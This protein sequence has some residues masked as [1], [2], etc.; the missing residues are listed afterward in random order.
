MPR[1]NT[2]DSTLDMK[3]QCTEADGCWLWPRRFQTGYGRVSLHGKPR[4]AH[5]LAW[6]LT[7]GP[8]PE[9]MHICHR[10]D[11]RACC[12]PDHLFLGTHREN[13]ADMVAKGRSASADRHPHAVLSPEQVAEIRR[14][15][16]DGERGASLAKEFGVGQAAASRLIRGR[17]WTGA[18][19]PILGDLRSGSAHHSA[20]LTEADVRAIRLDPR[21]NVVIAR[22]RNVSQAAI[23]EIRRRTTWKHVE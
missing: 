2:F 10:C 5:R 3:A 12:N 23:S 15:A 14:R 16:A 13:M 9:G 19:G 22:E 18:G 8:I 1:R 17:G 20:K 21:A 4:S 6:E 7:H 11:V